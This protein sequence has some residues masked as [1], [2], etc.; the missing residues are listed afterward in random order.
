MTLREDYEKET[1]DDIPSMYFNWAENT[2]FPDSYLKWLESRLQVS[3]TKVKK[4]R[5]GIQNVIDQKE[6]KDSKWIM[7]YL[8]QLLEP[9]EVSK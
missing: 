9:S 3:Q 5:S 2:P 7:G 8:G 4:L 6:P 1:G